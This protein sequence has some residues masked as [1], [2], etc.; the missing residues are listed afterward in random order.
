MF[1]LLLGQVIVE[2]NW[3]GTKGK[4]HQERE[5]KITKL[6]H[7]K[8]EIENW[9]QQM[10]PQRWDS[11]KPE[12]AKKGLQL[13]LPI[14]PREVAVKAYFAKHSVARDRVLT[15]EILK[16]ACG[17]LSPGDV[18]HYVKSDRFRQ[19]D[20]SHVTSE[21]AKL[22]EEQLLDLVRGG[23]DTCESIG[24]ISHLIQG[25]SLTSSARHSNTSWHLATW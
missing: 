25:K 10:G 21:K 14:N 15:A 16:Q 4:S 12:A 18:E 8:A 20:G 19:L 1:P 22:E 6:F 13:E 9:R 17:K 2:P 11:V 7:G 24:E 23:G 5:R 3:L